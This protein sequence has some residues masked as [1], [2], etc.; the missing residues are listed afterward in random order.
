MNVNCDKPNII[1]ILLDDLGYG[2]V[3]FTRSTDEDISSS[4]VLYNTPNIDKLARED[5]I[6][7]NRHYVHPICS[8]TRASFL[9]GKYP[10]TTGVTIPNF[11]FDIRAIS[12]NQVLLPS[13]LS[14]Y[15]NYATV[16]AGKWHVGGRDWDKTAL[17]FFDQATYSTSGF[18]TYYTHEN[19]NPPGGFGRY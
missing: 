14:Q 5:G 4:T 7:L 16:F 18:L 15:G 8:P 11:P 9:T 13:V 19:C 12:D 1:F 17:Q 2:D 3:G 6:I 10:S